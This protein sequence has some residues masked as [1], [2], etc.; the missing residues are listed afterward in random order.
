MTIGSINGIPGFSEP[1]NAWT[2]LLGAAVF[3]AL[4]WP[5]IRRGR[6]HP[7]RVCTLAIFAAS[8][9]L[10]LSMSG[11]YHMLQPGGGGRAVLQRL[12]HAAI[13]V[14]IA[15]TFTPI[16]TI[17]FRGVW[18]CGMLLFI[19]AAAATGIVLKTVFFDG[20]PAWLGVSIY[21]GMGWVGLASAIKVVRCLGYRFVAPLAYGA[22]AY[23]AGAGLL[24]LLSL[25]GEPMPV[26]GV[27]GR[28]ELFHLAVLAGMGF[29]W[30]FIDRI[31]D[32]RHCCST[33]R[34]GALAASQ[35][36]D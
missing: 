27:V 25:L 4:T 5:L 23:T 2:H 6:G 20:V 32:G 16:H 24:G 28:H 33:P 7:A 26:P 8:C 1:V 12:D 35:G 22:L 14:L 10:V 17:L 36:S 15:G 11:V 31:A 13:F 9:L 3:L 21:V 30:Q 34:H 18:R 19:W 29:H